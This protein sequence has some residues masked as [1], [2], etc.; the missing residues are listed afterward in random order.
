MAMEPPGDRTGVVDKDEEPRGDKAAEQAPAARNTVT[1]RRELRERGA[2][3]PRSGVSASLP[4]LNGAASNPESSGRVL[5][6]RSTRA[7]PA[8][9]KDSKSDEEE[10]DEPNVDSAAAKRRKV[11]SSRRKKHSES[12]AC[13]AAGLLAG[14][15]LPSTG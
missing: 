3:R 11:S 1:R 7:V 10:E 12:V 15:G 14:A 5:R 6:N 8:W 4:D 2:G 13:E 9:L